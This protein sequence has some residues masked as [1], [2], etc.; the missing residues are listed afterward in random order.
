MAIK[1]DKL[2]ALMAEKGL[3]TYK[4]RKQ[5]I[6]SQS[7]LQNLK[8]NKSVTIDTIDKLCV[9]LDCQPGDLM[10]YVPEEE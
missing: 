3:T 6:I 4:I 1:F 8:D 7:A 10:E 2:F 5:N 9:A